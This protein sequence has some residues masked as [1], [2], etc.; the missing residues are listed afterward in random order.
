[1]QCAGARCRV[2]HADG[3]IE[4]GEFPRLVAPDNPFREISAIA[5]EVAPGVWAE[6]RMDG[7]VFE[8][9]DQRNWT[10][11]SFKTFCT[12]LRLPFPVE[13]AEGTE[14]RQSVTLRLG[15]RPVGDVL[16][17]PEDSGRRKISLGGKAVAR[18]PQIGLGV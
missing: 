2:G 1:G 4:D 18:L 16:I 7:D 11:A 13:V 10:D 8:M 15:A 6:L 5:H 17:A 14:V 9:E 12:P 3:T